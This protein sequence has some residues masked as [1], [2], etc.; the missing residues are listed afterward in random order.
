SAVPLTVA[1]VGTHLIATIPGEM[2]VD[3]G[4]RVRGA[5]ALTANG[6]GIAGVQ[7]SGLANEYLSYF[8]SPQ[9]YDAQHYEGGSTMYGRESSVLVLQE[10]QL[11]TNALLTH[12]AA[13]SPDPSDPRNGI[14]DTAARF[15][16]G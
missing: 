15:G 6:H 10:L 3:M 4:R 1:Q 9:E 5:I 13:P 14:A 11:L 16:T 8:T 12:T 2:T 7:L